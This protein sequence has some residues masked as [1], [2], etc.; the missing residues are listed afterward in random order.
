MK[1]IKI[2]EYTYILPDKK[3]AKYPLQDRDKSKLLLY[4]DNVISSEKFLNLSI[5]LPQN[6]LLLMN[7][8]KVIYARL[9]FKK[10]TGAKIEIFCLNPY[11]P[12]EYN[13]AFEAKKSC[14]WE[15]IVGNFKKW[16][17]DRIFLEFKLLNKTYKL[18]AEKSG[19]LGD[20]QIIKF[21][22]D[23]DLTFGEILSLVGQIPIP[24]YLKRESEETDKDRY[25][26][27]YSKFEGSVAAPTAGLHFTQQ[28]F[29]QLKNK[30][31]K[32]DEVTLHVGAGTFKPIKT[33]SVKDHNM[34]TEYFVV[35]KSTLINILNNLGSIISVGTTTLRT[36]ES[37]YWLGVKLFHQIK[38]F[39]YIGQWECYELEAI[40][41][42]LAL[43]TIIDFLNKKEIEQIEAKTQIIIVPGYKF[44]IVDMLITNFHQPQS[45]LLLL[46]GAFIGDDW[47]KVYEY[48]LQNE[49]RFLS[50]G[51]SSLLFKKS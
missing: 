6:S 17:N 29:E 7:N 36:L 9:N 34:H 19:K 3:I 33:N 12:T 2:S 35:K 21:E 20:K 11:I 38:N 1:D 47:K 13:L 46:V 43:N 5:C 23:E 27:V 22:W 18:Y 10:I 50:Y 32:T 31:I 26:T 44:K 39:E 4:K 48:A 49:F 30:K 41:V 51:D 14:E 16:K 24:P 25:Q 40:N 37:I 42:K 15:C 45:T 8:T 28:I